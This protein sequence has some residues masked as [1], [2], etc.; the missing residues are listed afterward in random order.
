MN[1]LYDELKGEVIFS[2]SNGHTIK[3]EFKGII[4]TSSCPFLIVISE[5]FGKCLIAEDDISYIAIQ[6]EQE[7]IF[8]EERENMFK[9]EE[10]KNSKFREAINLARKKYR[11]TDFVAKHPMT[12][13]L[14]PKNLKD[15]EPQRSNPQK[16]NKKT[17]KPRIIGDE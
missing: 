5:I 16:S 2:M 15:Q 3:G 13:G 9:K 17:F 11:Q 1:N 14:E 12:D 7:N 6:E 8:K 10:R 4:E